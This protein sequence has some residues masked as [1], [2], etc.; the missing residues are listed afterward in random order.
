L[1]GLLLLFVSLDSLV[2]ATQLLYTGLRHVSSSVMRQIEKAK[3]YAERKGWTVNEEHV[4]SD[5]GI[6]GAEFVKRPGL[7]RL[8]AT[9]EQKPCPFNVLVMRSP[10]LD[11]NR[12][13]RAMS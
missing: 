13:R 1:P 7:V 5:D 3:A 9:L 4:Y 2:A 12:S 6:S 10:D 11:A 8:L